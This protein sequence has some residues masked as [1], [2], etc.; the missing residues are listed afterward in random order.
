MFAIGPEQHLIRLRRG[1]VIEIGVRNPGR[2]GSVELRVDVA[3][4]LEPALAY[5]AL[6]GALHVGDVVLLNTTAME[7][8]LGTGGFHLVVAV[9]GSADTDVG[10][11]GRVMKARYTPSQ[12]AVASVEETHRDLLEGSRGLRNTPVVCAPLHSMIAPISAGAKA[13]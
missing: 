10:H 8:G 2:A 7:L 9:E 13:S 4:R 5:P 6:V 11:P 12:V 1:T 3:G